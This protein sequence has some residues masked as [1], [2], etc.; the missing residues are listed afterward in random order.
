MTRKIVTLSLLRIR[1]RSLDVSLRWAISCQL[2]RNYFLEILSFSGIQKK[3]RILFFRKSPWAKGSVEE[4][5]E[6]FCQFNNAIDI[7]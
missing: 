2:H 3:V 4:H 1:L 7:D 6:S 5:E